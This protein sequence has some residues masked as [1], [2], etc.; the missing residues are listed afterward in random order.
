M[1]SHSEIESFLQEGYV[2]R[3]EVLPQT[4]IATYRAA[5]DS[6]SAQMPRRKGASILALR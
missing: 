6:H 3:R 1:L 5:V 4:D 2:I